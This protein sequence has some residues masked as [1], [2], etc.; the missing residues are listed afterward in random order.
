M[1]DEPDII[2]V[3]KV[4][5]LAEEARDFEERYLKFFRAGQTDSWLNRHNGGRN[6]VCREVSEETRAKM[7]T[8]RKGKPGTRKGKKNKKSYSFDRSGANNSFYGKMHSQK[9]IQRIRETKSKNPVKLV[10]EF[11]GMWG[12]HHTDESRRKISEKLQGHSNWNLGRQR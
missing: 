9:S 1:L 6:F 2:K 10:G 7:S 5:S 11:N 8:A 12:K 4:C 3:V